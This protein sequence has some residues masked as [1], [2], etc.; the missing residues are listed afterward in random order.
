[1]TVIDELTSG[2]NG[3]HEFGAVNHR[4]KTA[5]QQAD[6]VLAGITPEPL[7]LG[8]N[9]AELLFGQVAIIPLELLLGTQLNA[10]IA[11]LALAA[12]TML[13]AAWIFRWVVLMSVQGVPKYGAGLYLYDMP[14]GSDGLLGMIGVLGLCAALM[15]AVTYALERF[16]ARTRGLAA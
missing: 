12:L 14:W 2:K 7:C 16:P 11:Q 15:A 1:M 6:Q 4:I 10:E 9:P 8:K 5:L 3:G 13:A